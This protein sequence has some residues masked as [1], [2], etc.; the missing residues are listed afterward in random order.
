MNVDD[1]VEKNKILE[2]VCGSTAYGFA[3]PESD[4]DIRGLTI[5]PVEYV[6]GLERFDQRE[7]S[8]TDKVIYGLKKFVDLAIDN[9]PNIIELLYMPEKH[10]RFIDEWGEML[11]AHAHLFLSKKAKM[12]FS[13]Y[14]IS[15]LKRIQRHKRWIDNPPAKPNP[16][17]FEFKRYMILREDPENGNF[18]PTKTEKYNYDKHEGSKW[19]EKG[20]SSEYDARLKEHNLYKEW[21]KNRNPKRHEIEE[22]FHY[23][24]KHAAHLVRLLRMGMEI[25][26]D[27]KVYVD[28]RDVGDAEE[29][30][31]IRKGS[32]TYDEILE[33]AE[34]AELELNDLYEKNTTLQH[35]ADRVAINKLYMDIVCGKLGIKYGL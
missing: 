20:I 35:S 10:I 12:T 1:F 25:L 15:Q 8:E 31:A 27:G 13:G 32:M 18:M 11:V 5:P 26:R 14:A 23:D 7:Y 17:D 3:T 24:T 9:N 29:F 34:K 30:R 28:R 22:K 4:E 16:M 21:Q 2:C 19:V 33:Y 6:I